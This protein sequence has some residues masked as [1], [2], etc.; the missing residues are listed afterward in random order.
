MEQKLAS[1]NSILN[2]RKKAITSKLARYRKELEVLKEM[3]GKY[4]EVS[5]LVQKSQT[6]KRAF[7]EELFLEKRKMEDPFSFQKEPLFLKEERHLMR[8]SPL[9]GLNENSLCDL[10]FLED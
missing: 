1:L 8:D 7:E 2:E 9:L 4:Q 6:F 3:K 10:V 5:Q